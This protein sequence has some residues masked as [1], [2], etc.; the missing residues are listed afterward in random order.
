M[1]QGLD[2]VPR[3]KTRLHGEFQPGLKFYPAFLMS[4]PCGQSPIK[5]QERITSLV[6]SN[7]NSRV[8]RFSPGTRSEVPAQ[9]GKTR[10]RLTG[11]EISHVIVFSP[12]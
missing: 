7:N 1:S 4:H 10:P 3:P 9:S 11:M 6:K 2:K 5:K 8:K 12:G